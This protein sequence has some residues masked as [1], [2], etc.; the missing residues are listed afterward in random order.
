VTLGALFF[1]LAVAMVGLPPLSV[2]LGKALILNAA[3]G[4]PLLPWVMGVVLFG[5]LCGLIAL[6]RSGS[7]LFYR[8]EPVADTA[9]APDLWALAPVLGLMVLI[10]GLTLFAGPL[11]DLT[12]AIAGDLLD[13]ATQILAV[14][15][16]A[17]G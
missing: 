9:P 14:L 17:G 4:H 12:L 1:V 13:P 3:L 11:S 7:L 2:F 10:L 8:P 16:G 6:A 15:S 5:G